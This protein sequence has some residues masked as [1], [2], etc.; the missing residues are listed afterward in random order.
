MYHDTDRVSIPLFKDLFPFGGQLNANNDWVKLV[1]LIPWAELEV[2]YR[3]YFCCDR[4]RPAKECQLICGLLIAKHR[5]S[6]SDRRVV[7]LVNENPYVQFFCGFDQFVT[8]EKIIHPSLLS[9]MRRRL[10]KEFFALF[11]G[12][13]L[14][15]LVEHG[16]IWAK[17]Q[18]IDA[19]VIPADISYPTDCK[20][21]NEAREWLCKMILR[22]KRR[23]GIREQVRTYRRV[24]K[25]VYMAFTKRRKKTRRYIRKVQGKMLRFVRRNLGQIEELLERVPDEMAG[26]KER[27]AEKVS[28]IRCLYSQQKEM[29]ER[30]VRRV[31]NRIVSIH[32]LHIRPMV[33]GKEGKDVEFGPKVVLSVVDGYGFLDHFSFDA[34]NESGHLEGSVRQYEDRFGQKPKVVIADKI[35]GTREN[36]SYLEEEEIGAAFKPLG[37]PRDRPDKG[38]KVWMKRQ[39]K[40]RN[41]IEGLIGTSKTRYGLERIL[42]SIP[43]GEEI[44][45]RMGLM[46]M[47]LN[48]AVVRMMT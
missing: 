38:E 4:G 7:K 19:T 26:F 39:Q 16:L 13:V 31:E 22:V 44:W 33:R 28:V 8:S 3:R 46:G 5:E 9:K 42:Y 48:R 35:F 24:G 17:E 6:L 47:N 2:V 14:R 30:R 20:L 15:V 32:R 1:G 45:V 10:G 21:L 41:C 23:A 36:R 29:W 37:R 12:E 11:E 40:K 27:V 18:L 34:Y 43:D 25:W